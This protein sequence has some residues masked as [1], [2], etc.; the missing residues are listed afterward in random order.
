MTIG[1][2]RAATI[3]FLGFLIFLNS[4]CSFWQNRVEL[5]AVVIETV[6]DANDNAPVAVDIVAVS[7]SALIPTVQALTAA[8]W[9]NAKSQLLRDA[10]DGLRVWSLELVPG[11][12]FVANENPLLGAQAEA[13]LLFARYRSEGEHRLRLDNADALHLLLMTDEAVLAP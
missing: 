9:F 2:Y 4:G 10:P 7:D 6:P 3:L 5:K 12:R 13:I 11:S 8:Q 1:Q